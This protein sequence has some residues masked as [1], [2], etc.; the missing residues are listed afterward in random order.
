MRTTSPTRPPTV[1]R[2]VP[3]AL[4]AMLAL[5]GCVSLQSAGTL[6]EQVE[7]EGDV[8]GVAI[9]TLVPV[10]TPRAT[11]P[12]LVATP[13]P[14]PTPTRTPV[15]TPTPTVAPTVTPDPTP[16]PRPTLR[17]RPRPRKGPFRMD[18][19]RRG[20]FVS[21]FESWYCLPAAMQTML[22][23]LESGRQDRSRRTQD[24]LYRLARRF[25]T[26]KLEGKGAEPVG[27]ARA[28]EHLGHGEW[29][30]KAYRTRG[31]AVKAAAKALRMS[32]KP[33]GMLTWRGAHSWV[34]S[35]FRASA[36][37]ALTDRYQV[38]SIAI[39]DVWYP[40][41]SSIWGRSDPP[42][43]WMPVADLG[44]DFLR[45]NRWTVDYPGLDGRYVLVMP[46]PED[47]AA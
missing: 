21:Q 32:G 42:G 2:V 13:S 35:G 46:V 10:G 39:Q 18:L 29:E 6:Q 22:N 26:D 38:T 15:P 23:I 36:D 9:E 43:T 40:R 4:A 47:P 45:Y 34:M 37:P 14:V 27:W 31:Q 11:D 3:L 8:T 5:G 41:V 28:L 16:T 1:S 25:S 17:L 12:L 24:R 30:V 44:R 7:P 20:D 19:Y 33:V